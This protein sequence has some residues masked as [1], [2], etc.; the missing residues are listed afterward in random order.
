MRIIDWS[1]DVCSADLVIDIE[2]KVELGGPTHSK[3][4]LILSSFIAARYAREHP[5]S[6]SASLV[7]E[8]SYGRVDGGSASSA[9]LYRSAEGHRGKGRGR[10]CKQRRATAH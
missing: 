8:Q 2:R 6:L 1:S 9:E 3:G 7:F 4:V 10:T 5:L